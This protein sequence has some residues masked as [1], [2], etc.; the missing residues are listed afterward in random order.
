MAAPTRE[1][2]VLMDQI[3][4]FER[5]LSVTE[6]GRLNTLHPP[7]KTPELFERYLPH[8]IA[9]NV[10]NRWADKFRSVLEAASADP[11]RQQGMGWYSGSSSPWS[12]PGRFASSVGGALTSSV[13]SASTAPGSSSGSGGGG[14]SGGGGGGGGGGGW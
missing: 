8:A 7:E 6:E 3:A 1:G 12:N 10:E 4:G 2:R 5:Y 11:S 14:S 13:A 9:L